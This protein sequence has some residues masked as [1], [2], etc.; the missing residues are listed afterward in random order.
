M[1]ILK[2]ELLV[3]GYRVDVFYYDKCYQATVPN[4]PGVFTIASTLE[5]LDVMVHEAIGLYL[6]EMLEAGLDIP[7][8][9]QE[10]IEIG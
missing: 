4:L 3:L 1:V 2:A 6:E 9:D 7:K 5:E 10:L 8:P